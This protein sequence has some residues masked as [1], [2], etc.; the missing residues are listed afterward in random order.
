MHTSVSLSSND[1]SGQLFH[2]TALFVLTNFGCFWHIYLIYIVFSVQD[3]NTS[4]S[5]G[6]LCF[7]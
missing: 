5:F 4:L 1:F 2:F 3:D 7:V 6:T